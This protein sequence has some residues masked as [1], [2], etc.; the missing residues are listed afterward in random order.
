[1]LVP[2][3]LLASVVGLGFETPDGFNFT[4]VA[5]FVSVPAALV[6]G[7]VHLYL[8][9]AGHGVRDRDNLVVR[10][11]APGGGTVIDL[12]PQS[13]R[14][15][16]LADPAAGEHYVDLAAVRWNPQASSEA[17]YAA[18]PLATFFDERLVGNVADAGIGVGDEVFAIGLTSVRYAKEQN[19]PV[20]RTGHIAMI[21][22][23]PILVRF[24]KDGPELRMRLYL[25]ELRANAGLDGAPVFA[26]PRD[27]AEGS[28]PALLGTLV[29]AWDEGDATDLGLTKV[30]PA[31]L[32]S[33]LL[34][35][36]DEVER[37][38]EAEQ[39]PPDD[40][41]LADA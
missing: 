21:P 32:L 25:T 38:H 34:G 12:L 36:G 33:D 19:A 40:S 4:G 30:L 5:Y 1:M 10:L 35:Q 16:R 18:I 24:E 11:N 13:D 15:L 6:P 41:W 7:K 27:A 2:R 37:R 28:S 31:Q 26:R 9:T 22:A 17:G 8:V 23:E 39:G 20:V 14:W 29:G 3:E